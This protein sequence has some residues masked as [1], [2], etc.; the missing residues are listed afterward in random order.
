MKK[1]VISDLDGTLLMHHKDSV[2]ICDNAINQINKLMTET[3]NVFS[4]ATGRHYKDVRNLLAN[5][6]FVK[7][8]EI[9]IIGINGNQIYSPVSD[10]LIYENFL[11]KEEIKNFDNI[12]DFMSEK[13][14]KKY[15]LYGYNGND[16]MFFINDGSPHFN[17]MFEL[18]KSY[19]S[20]NGVFDYVT[21]KSYKEIDNIYKLCLYLMD[22]INIEKLIEDHLSKIEKNLTFVCVGNNFIEVVN[23]GTSKHSA[24]KVL[25]KKVYPE[26][27]M[28]KNTIIF[29]DSG[30]DYE[31]MKHAWVAI[32]NIDARKQ[33]QEIA[34]L[35][36][37]E[38]AS[39][40]VAKG[41]K[42]FIFDNK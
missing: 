34:T 26:I 18:L 3:N 38:Q 6:D 15:L 13:F 5:F 36:Y 41:I 25:N 12:L 30:N 22:E 33:I 39:E 24:L 8:E 27:N 40:F 11:S 29:G 23:K 4:I 10:S 32:T 31:M 16:E 17:T 19:E 37:K 7:K 21:Y 2:T 14:G 35:I 1:W 9:F 28:E 20:N 42:E